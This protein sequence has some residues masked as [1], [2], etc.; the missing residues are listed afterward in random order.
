MIYTEN[1]FS[2]LCVGISVHGKEKRYGLANTAREN[3]IAPMERI[4]F[5]SR[6]SG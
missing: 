2:D 5:N 6:L 4:L 1:P 3:T